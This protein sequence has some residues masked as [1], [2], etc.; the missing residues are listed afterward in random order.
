MDIRWTFINRIPKKNDI[1]APK[2]IEPA[3]FLW[4]VKR[5]N[6]WPKIWKNRFSEVWAYT[7]NAAK[8]WIFIAF[9]AETGRYTSVCRVA[10]LKVICLDLGQLSA[11]IRN[12]RITVYLIYL[13]SFNPEIE[14]L[15][16]PLHLNFDFQK[17]CCKQN[18]GA[19]KRLTLAFTL[20]SFRLLACINLTSA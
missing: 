6:H 14:I 3:I 10:I 16:K 15:Q 20:W 11:E 19:R 8:Y 18:V 12:L 7:L 4:L 17:Q 9:V 5:S 13:L 2:G 1:W